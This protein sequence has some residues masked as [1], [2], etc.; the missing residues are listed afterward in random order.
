[1]KEFGSVPRQTPKEHHDRVV[2]SIVKNI[3]FLHRTKEFLHIQV[4]NRQGD[5][6][7]DTMEVPDLNPRDLFKEEFER[8]TDW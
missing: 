1:M 2:A 6:L 3:D 4:Y 8:P 5:R 7:C